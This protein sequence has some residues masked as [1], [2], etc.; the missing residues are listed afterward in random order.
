[1]CVSQVLHKNK[2]LL[3]LSV[4]GPGLITACADNDAGGITTYSAAGAH[5]G[6]DML[7]ILFVS[8]VSLMIVQEM[9]ARMGAVTGKGLSDL[10]RE[11]FGV[12]WVFFAMTVLALANIATTASEFSGI[13]T[14]FEIFGISK[15]VSVPVMAFIV[16]GS[17]VKGSYARVEK[18][19]FAL[20]LTFLSYIVTGFIVQPPWQEVISATVM[21]SFS[22][23]T[24]YLMMVIGMI[25]TTITPWGQFYIQSSVV[26]KGIS[27]KDYK[28]I[29][30]DVFVGSFFTG[31]V[32]FFIIVVTSVVLHSN[33]VVI[34]TAQDAAQALEPLAGKYAAILYAFGLFGASMLAAFILPLSTAYAVCEA[35]GFESGISKSSKEAPIFFGIYTTLILLGALLVLWPGISLYGIMMMAQVVNGILL[36]PILIFMLL[37]ANNQQLM[38]AYTN[39]P[40]FNILAWAQSIVLILLTVVLVA[41]A[42]FPNNLDFFFQRVLHL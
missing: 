42:F 28:Y 39:S 20:C 8:I 38:G 27:V 15:Y 41:A 21:P 35:F 36:P 4:M 26:D 6:F 24:S 30:L 7:L 5:Y 32:A 2:L 13:A 14:S 29:R 3:F 11:Q 22:R 9:S 40:I 23:D 10:I 31:L 1:M 33:G 34:E 25:G 12:K 19:F 17:V 37:I 18:I 16:W